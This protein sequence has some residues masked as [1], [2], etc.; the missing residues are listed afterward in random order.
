M[1][2]ATAKAKPAVQ[3]EKMIEVRIRFWTDDIAPNKDE[4]IPKHAWMSGVVAM[5]RNKSHG[6]SPEA[7][8]PFNSLLSLGSAIE[9]V[10]I[11]HGVVFHVGGR[12]KKYMRD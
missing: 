1:T 4:I 8:I 2:D 6:I 10:L 5:D 11:A 9:K 7:P 3:G 12:S